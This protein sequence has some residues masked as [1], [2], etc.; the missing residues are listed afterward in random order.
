[1]TPVV[2]TAFAKSF[3]LLTTP[4]KLLDAACTIA[5]AGTYYLILL[6]A[7]AA[8]ADASDVTAG[9]FGRY[10]GCLPITTSASNQT[11]TL[12]ATIA[13]YPSDS[14]IRCNLGCVVLLSSTA[15]TS[16]TGVASGLWVNG[17][18]G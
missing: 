16:V 10:L 15:P 11:V 1:M 13:G 14:G 7:V 2:S 5:A 9:A 17:S 3:V 6:D 8:P 4:G 12:D 18:V